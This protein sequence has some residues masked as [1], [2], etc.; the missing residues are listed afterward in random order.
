MGVATDN[1]DFA[2]DKGSRLDA[3]LFALRR[4][5]GESVAHVDNRAGRFARLLD[6]QRRLRRRVDRH[7]TFSPPAGGGDADDHCE[8][9]RRA[10]LADGEQLL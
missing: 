1:L 8:H 6:S 2:V 4:L 5:A 3:V 10:L 7:G 9:C